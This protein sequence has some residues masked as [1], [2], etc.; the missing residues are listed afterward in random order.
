IICSRYGS[1]PHVVLIPLVANKS[2]T[3]QGMPCSGPR[4]LPRLIS[5]SASSACLSASSSVSVTTQSSFGPY[6]FSRPRYILVSST[7]ETFFVRT[8]SESCVTVQK[9]RSSSE[10]Y[11]GTSTLLSLSLPG[12]TLNFLPGGAG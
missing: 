3:P 9:A 12:L 5:C 10:L 7:G 4:Y 8:S 2:F 6:F 1:A 11:F